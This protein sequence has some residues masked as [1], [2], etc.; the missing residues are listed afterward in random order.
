MWVLLST[1]TMYYV[2]YRTYRS[3]IQF[4]LFRTKLRAK[5]WIKDCKGSLIT[6]TM[7]PFKRV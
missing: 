3:E 5:R 7:G 6:N 4:K 1:L 2:F